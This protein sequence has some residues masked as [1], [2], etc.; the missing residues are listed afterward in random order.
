[1]GLGRVLNSLP[2]PVGWAYTLLM[3]MVG[4]VFFRADSVAGAWAMLQAMAGFGAA[5]PTPY[6]AGPGT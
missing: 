1:M 5:E 2:A 6:S 3:V 4:W